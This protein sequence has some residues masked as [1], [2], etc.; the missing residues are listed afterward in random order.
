MV[1]WEWCISISL[2]NV[3][4]TYTLWGNFFF[5][6]P[7]YPAHSLPVK[8]AEASTV[9][10]HKLV[11]TVFTW[12]VQLSCSCIIKALLLQ[13]DSLIQALLPL[14]QLHKHSLHKRDCSKESTTFMDL[15]HAL[16][17][18]Q[19]WK[20]LSLH[21]SEASSHRLRAIEYN[22]TSLFPVASQ[23]I[24]GIIPASTDSFT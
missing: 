10:N 6:S 3:S 1:L 15:K 18:S 5:I 4:C 11:L 13:G 24:T 14:L 12:T 23:D 2:L 8:S 9:A 22:S 20:G 7:K 17:H 16:S 19:V 21:P